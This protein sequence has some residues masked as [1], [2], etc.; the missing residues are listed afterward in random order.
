[1]ESRPESPQP[2][3]APRWVAMFYRPAADSWRTAAQSPHRSPVLYAL[4]EMTRAVR[5]RGDEVT[6][7]L[8]GPKDGA[9]HR[10][11][12]PQ[13]QTAVS[14]PDPEPSPGEP[15]TLAERMTGRRHQVLMAGLTN[16][17]LYDLSPEDDTTVQTLVERLDEAAVRRIAD[18]LTAA[19]GTR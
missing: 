14:R 2:Q 8:W 11:D 17:G 4:G 10:Y 9:W 5:A 18:W 16:A 13:Q 19:G 12:A 7:A 15:A 1:M 6:V 3:G